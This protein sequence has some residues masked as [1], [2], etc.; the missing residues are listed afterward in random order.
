LSRHVL[1]LVP[2]VGRA[3]PHGAPLLVSGRTARVVIDSALG[4]TLPPHDGFLLSHFHEDHVVGVASSG[5]PA[6][7]HAADLAAT[8]SWSGFQAS[9]GYTSPAWRDLV[10]GDFGW[11]PVERAT[12]LDLDEPIDLG[13]VRVVPIPLP[14]HTP[15]HTGYLVEPDGMLYLGDVDLSSFGPYYG[16]A[17]SSLADTERSLDVVADVPAR[18]WATFHH[19]GSTSSRSTFE[20]SLAAHRAVVGRRSEA[21]RQLLH[22]GPAGPVDARA[23][24]GRGVVY[25][26]GTAPPWGA[27]GE[28][29]MIQQHLHQMGVPHVR[30]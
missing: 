24:V 14:G 23:L 28:L 4:V 6:R 1:Q 29:R 30:S 3:Y 13:G 18:V 27:E 5:L 7:V 17:G 25:R 20:S 11:T 9:S 10:L 26:P 21:L 2:D 19:K 15:G 22:E 16:D 12:A 8:T